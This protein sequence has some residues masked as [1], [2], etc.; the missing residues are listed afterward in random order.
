MEREQAQAVVREVGTM[1][2]IPDLELDE[3]G[4]CSLSINEE[5]LRVSILHDADGSLTIIATL[6]GVEPTEAVLRGS[7]EANYLWLG[8]SGATFCLNGDN[9]KVTLVQSASDAA[10]PQ[11]LMARLESLVEMA[12][13]WQDEF[14]EIELEARGQPQSSER[15]SDRERDLSPSSLRNAIEV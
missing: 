12:E 15:Q 4:A 9:D 11:T 7:M 8:T 1:I 10:D 13:A 6:Q 14:A 2:G 3:S 5:R